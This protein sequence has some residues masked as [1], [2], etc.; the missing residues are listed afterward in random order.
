MTKDVLAYIGL[1]AIVAVVAQV[2]FDLT[3][4]GVFP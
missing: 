3:Q 1:L 4:R 2:A